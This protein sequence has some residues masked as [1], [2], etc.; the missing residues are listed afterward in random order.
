MGLP[1]SRCPCDTMATNSSWNCS[2][3]VVIRLPV[4]AGVLLLRIFM[5][6]V[7]PPAPAWVLL[8]PNCIIMPIFFCRMPCHFLELPPAP[9]A[10]VPPP[11][12]CEPRLSEIA[13]VAAP[14][15]D[16]KLRAP[17]L[18]LMEALALEPRS[19]KLE[20]FLLLPSSVVRSWMRP[21]I[22]RAA[23]PLLPVGAA[24]KWTFFHSMQ[25][26]SRIQPSCSVWK[27]MA[28]WMPPKMK[29]SSALVPRAECSVRA[30]GTCEA[31]SSS[32]GDHS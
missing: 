13:R 18:P 4:T 26:V 12:R 19:F 2:S 1:S 32:M 22:L 8:P 24:L 25:E 17:A 30:G 31:A 11:P 10:K 3:L 27:G 29:I 23:E 6:L 28:E 21:V 9:I 20:F 14:A 7:P 16:A 15:K 5:A